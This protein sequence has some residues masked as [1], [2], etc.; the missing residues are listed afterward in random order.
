MKIYSGIFRGAEIEYGIIDGTS[1]QMYVDVTFNKKENN[2]S[3]TFM[4]DMQKKRSMLEYLFAFCNQ[5]NGLYKYGKVKGL[6]NEND[7]RN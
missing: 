2:F 3:W 4:F 5:I 6:E 1:G 7:E